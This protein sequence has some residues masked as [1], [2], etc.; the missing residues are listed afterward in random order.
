MNLRFLDTAEEEMTEAARIYEDQAVGSVAKIDL[1]RS[2]VPFSTNTCLNGQD[3]QCTKYD[4]MHIE[5]HAT[6]ESSS[7]ANCRRAQAAI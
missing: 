2:E 7:T 5:K 1:P 4:A 3:A 6:D